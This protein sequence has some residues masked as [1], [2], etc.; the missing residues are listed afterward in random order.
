MD[1]SGAEL[2]KSDGTAAGTVLVKDIYPPG[3]YGSSNPSNFTNVNGTLFFTANDGTNGTELWKSDG[4]DGRHRPGQGHRRGSR[5]APAPPTS[6]TSTAR[7]SS[8]A[9]DPSSGTELWKSDGT[10]AGTVLVKDIYAGDDRFQPRQP[11]QRQR[12]AVLRGRR[13]HATATSCG[14]ATAPRPAPSW[15]RTSTRAA[16]GSSPANLTNVNGT[17]FFA[18]TTAPTARAVEE[19]RHRRRHRPGQGHRRRER[20]LQSQLSHQRQRHAVLPAADGTN[21]YELWKS[22]GTAAGTVLVKDI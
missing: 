12:H 9:S 18:P 14:R 20:R 4:T 19:R 8:A 6:P 7:C 10:A 3:Y 11:H 16:D 1:T 17:L 5:V 22:D 13:R 2:W 15:S 21:G